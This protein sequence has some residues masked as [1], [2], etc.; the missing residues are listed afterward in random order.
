MTN[1]KGRNK[2]QAEQAYK[3]KEKERKQIHRPRA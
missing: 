2:K 1:R 3:E